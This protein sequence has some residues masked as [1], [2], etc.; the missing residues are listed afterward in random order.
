MVAEVKVRGMTFWAV[1]ELKP[2]RIE[3]ESTKVDDIRS[4]SESFAI[5]GKIWHNYMHYKLEGFGFVQGEPG[6][7]TWEKRPKACFWWEM[8]KTSPE[9]YRPFYDHHC[10]SKQR[11]E[12][13]LNLLHDI[14][15]AIGV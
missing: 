11:Q 14:I 8:Y 7:N 9:H 13:M 4:Y 2:F 12:Q 1:E 3:I 15:E 5:L 10:S 6:E